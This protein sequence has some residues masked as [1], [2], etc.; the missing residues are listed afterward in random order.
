[1]N[2]IRGICDVTYHVVADAKPT[3]LAIFVYVNEQHNN[4]PN[5]QLTFRKGFRLNTT[6]PA[7]AETYLRR[8]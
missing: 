8:V 3:N 5:F 7:S 4:Q 2:D 1:M 6:S